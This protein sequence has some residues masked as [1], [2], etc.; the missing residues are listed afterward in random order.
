[1][2]AQNGTP[3]AAGLGDPGS[4]VG[5]GLRASVADF[6]VRVTRANVSRVIVT[7]EEILPLYLALGFPRPSALR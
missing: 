5:V 4:A 2:V 1:M 3:F 6:A 7:G